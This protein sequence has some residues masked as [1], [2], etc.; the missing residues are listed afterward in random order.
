[1]TLGLSVFSNLTSEVTCDTRCDAPQP[2]L[3]LSLKVT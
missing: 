3:E 2:D 1:M